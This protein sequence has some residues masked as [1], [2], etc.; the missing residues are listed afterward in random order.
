[1]FQ[2]FVAAVEF[3]HERNHGEENYILNL[4]NLRLCNWSCGLLVRYRQY[5]TFNCK[6]SGIFQ[7]RD[8]LCLHV[9]HLLSSHHSKTSFLWACIST[10]TLQTVGQ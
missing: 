2:L 6:I 3:N 9:L 8:E 5:D 10:P 7:P 4:Q 1:M